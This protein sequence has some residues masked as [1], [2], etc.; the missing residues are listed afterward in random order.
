[1]T[2]PKLAIVYYGTADTQGRVSQSRLWLEHDSARSSGWTM[3]GQSFFTVPPRLDDHPNQHIKEFGGAFKPGRSDQEADKL[4]VQWLTMGVTLTPTCSRCGTGLSHH[5]APH[6]FD[7][8][9]PKH[10]VPGES[11]NVGNN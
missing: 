5:V 4:A 1:M 9:F 8:C 11:I 2:K 3:R 7:P 6:E 10:Y